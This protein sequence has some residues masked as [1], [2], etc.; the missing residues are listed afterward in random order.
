MTTYTHTI[1]DI[2]SI[3]NGT[4]LLTILHTEITTSIA[5]FLGINPNGV[6]YYFHKSTTWSSGNITT[7]TSVI[8]AHTGT[9]PPGGDDISIQTAMTLVDPGSGTN[10][11]MLISPD[12]VSSSYTITLPASVGSTGQTLKT[13]DGIG[14]LG[15]SSSSNDVTAAANMTANMLLQGDDGA[16]GVKDSTITVT[17]DDELSAVQS[18]S[19][20]Q[21]SDFSTKYGY[22]ALNSNTGDNNSAFGNLA[23]LSNL[24]G[25]DNSAFGSRSIET[26]ISGSFNTAFGSQSLTLNSTGGNNTA[27]GC[28]ALR[29]ATIGDSTAVGAFALA[30]IT[31]GLRNTG[32]GYFSNVL[33][34]TGNDNTSL[35]H[36]SLA[37]NLSSENTAIG[38]NSLRTNT[39]GTQ[40]TALGYNSLY[41]NT[42]ASGGTHNTALGHKSI[43]SA[44]ESTDNTSVGSE[45]MLNVTG[46]SH[47]NVAIGRKAIGIS[48][49]VISDNVAIGN[50]ALLNTQGNKQ[51]AIGSSALLENTTG[52]ENVGVGYNTLLTNITGNN[53]T[54]IG[55]KALSINIA[56]ENTAIGSNALELNSASS[57]LVAV[58][59]KAL[60]ANVSGDNNTAMGYQSLEDLQSG[61]ANTA[62]GYKT[63]NKNILG[64][65]NTAVGYHALRYN[66]EDS[67]TGVGYEALTYNTTGIHNTALGAKT[68]S[69]SETGLNNTALGY[70]SLHYSGYGSTTVSHNTAVGSCSLE[71][72][73]TGENNTALGSNS[74]IVLETGDSNIA[75]GFESGKLYTAAES[76]NI[77]IGHVGIAA[78]SNK[79]RIGTSSTH[80]SCYI[81]GI[82][83]ISPGGTPQLVIIDPADGQLGS[84]T[85]AGVD[86]TAIHNNIASEISAIAA[87][88][89]PVNADFLLIEDSANSNN[90]K[91]ITIGDLPSSAKRI[92]P[93]QFGGDLDSDNRYLV[94]NGNSNDSDQ[95]STSKT[96][97][98]LFAGTLIKATYRCLGSGN[99]NQVILD[100]VINA[101]G[102]TNLI[103]LNPSGSSGDYYETFNLNISVSD[104]DKLEIQ[105]DS[106]T[107]GGSGSNRMDRTV[108]VVLLELD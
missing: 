100:F 71:T 29:N 55:H 85:I 35:G 26:N 92:I 58:G 87:K 101:S 69:Y 51:I 49:S 79:I 1:S 47:R 95:T 84:T 12:P 60:Y 43:S 18:I 20:L 30:E 94:C 103:T 107:P 102:G 75:I 81:Q 34:V 32:I 45:S 76:N 57:G 93:L 13:T 39:L 8:T 67:I 104:G 91:R 53:N 21:D 5:D 23:G 40:N 46:A 16:K 88:G 37:V 36:R 66:E 64:V 56:S 15:W 6:T 97:Y 42:G 78:E 17:N 22:N 72:L 63:L 77:L 14:T 19:L 33:C 65:D 10:E 73:T 28:W 7:L 44:N 4:I 2:T 80:T 106:S 3:N 70:N 41:T 98:P 96:R 25:N 62:I 27:I 48:S 68:L 31:T 59:Y 11:I 86:S 24:A 89:T 50:K 82:H 108:M 38:T 9:L 105:Y 83:G 52:Y 74:L 61:N 99:V 90:K 54:A